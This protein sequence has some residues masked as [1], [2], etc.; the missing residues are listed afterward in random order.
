MALTAILVPSVSARADE[1]ANKRAEAARL[2]AQIDSLGLQE[3]ALSEQYDKAV[4]DE[5]N[6]S[7]A[8]SAAEDQVR[9]ATAARQK[10]ADQVRQFAVESYVGG[11]TSVLAQSA[12]G[13]L[14]T[15]DA[16]LLRGEYIRVLS[17]NRD[18]AVDQY[19]LA[20]IQAQTTRAQLASAEQ[21]AAAQ[22][23]AVSAARTSV[24]QTQAQLQATYAQV[25]GQ[26]AT[27]VAQAQAAE[28]ARRQQEAQAALARQR[29]A[30]QARQAALAAAQRPSVAPHAS[31]ASAP[32]P[33]RASAVSV[34]TG[35][36]GAAAVAA[37][38]SRLGD[39]Y[40]WGAA[41]PDSFD[42]S[43]LTMW[44][45]AH[46]GVSLPH[47]SGAQYSST[48]HIPMSDLQPGDLVFFADPGEHVAMYIG[49]G[50]IIEAPHT[51]AVVHIAPLYS[52]FVLASR[53]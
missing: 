9:R 11:G 23:L 50:Q 12:G 31:L 26:L 43:G 35:S 41:G 46:A 22:V 36:G 5:Q 25:N 27:L 28:A 30:E 47:F 45:W 40:V 4:L 19:R 49:N 20:S 7:K 37:A 44:A 32:A 14:M 1:I 16:S 38:E 18:D 39:P 33:A 52:Q 10:A 6:A 51:G 8:V 48:T 13:G 53:P 42:C 2:A 24:T 3:S 21:Q 29:A 34:P 17:S 15:A